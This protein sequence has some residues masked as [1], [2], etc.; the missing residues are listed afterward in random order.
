MKRAKKLWH[1]VNKLSLLQERDI[2]PNRIK[3]NS[4]PKKRKKLSGNSKKFVKDII[5][6]EGSR[7]TKSA[8]NC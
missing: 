2:K 1:K 5:T 6:G 8:T 7:K 4:L 3:N